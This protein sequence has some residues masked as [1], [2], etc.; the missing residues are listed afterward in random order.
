MTRI[1][2]IGLKQ[3]SNLPIWHNQCQVY[4]IMFDTT[5][6]RVKGLFVI[7]VAMSATSVYMNGIVDCLK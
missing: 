2:E 4:V 7:V 6:A 5:M 1:V 3:N